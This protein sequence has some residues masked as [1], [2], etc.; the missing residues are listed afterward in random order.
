M[1]KSLKLIIALSLLLNLMLAG[2]IVGFFT[3]RVI[4]HNALDRDEFLN[5]VNLPE[6]KKKFFL[7]VMQSNRKEHMELR[8]RV[9]EGREKL[10]DIL[11]AKVFDEIAFENQ[12]KEFQKLRGS[13][14]DGFTDTMRSIGKE[15]TAEERKVVVEHLR[16]MRE[17]RHRKHGH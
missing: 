6:E 5:S 13:L 17:L 2:I 9:K 3:Q 10:L 12:A 14:T 1:T 4:P 7:N 8:E 11:S 15:F 16:K